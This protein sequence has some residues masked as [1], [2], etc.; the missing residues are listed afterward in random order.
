MDQELE[1]FKTE[2]DLRDYAASL[3]FALNVNLNCRNKNGLFSRHRPK[4]ARL[5][6]GHA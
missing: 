3:G 2:I 1:R 4:T 5:I 6:P